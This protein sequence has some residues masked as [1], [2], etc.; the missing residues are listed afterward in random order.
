MLPVQFAKRLVLCLVLCT[1]LVASAYAAEETAGEAR[2]WLERMSRALATSNYDVRFLHLTGGHAENMRI[3]HRV[4]DG[5]V[6]ERLV[7]LDGSGREVV[8]T[9]TEV[10]CY[11]PDRRTALV[12]KRTDRKSLLGTVPT[13]SDALQAYYTLAAPVRDRATARQFSLRIQ[14]MARSGNRHAVEIA[15]LRS[16]WTRHRANSFFRIAHSNDYRS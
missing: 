1:G 8:R 13:Y 6:T 12:E 3:I 16:R 5:A 7:S 4:A 10:V 15:A 2:A 11:L 14:I 9:E